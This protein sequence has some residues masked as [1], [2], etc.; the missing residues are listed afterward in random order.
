M[1][2]SAT[3]GWNLRLAAFGRSAWTSH[4]A[5]VRGFAFWIGWSDR[6]ASL[7]CGRT[8]VGKS[9]H[10]RDVRAGTGGQDSAV[11]TAGG[12]EVCKVQS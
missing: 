5:P 7:G 12:L 4:R 8:G 3:L 11:V 2:G 10:H 9:G 6:N 1:P